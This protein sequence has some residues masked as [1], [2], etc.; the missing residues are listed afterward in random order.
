[1]GNNSS[2]QGKQGQDF[3]G[4]DRAKHDGGKDA[5]GRVPDSRKHPDSPGSIQVQPESGTERDQEAEDNRQKRSL[6]EDT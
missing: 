5:S 3:G 1:M 6:D 2:G 4:K